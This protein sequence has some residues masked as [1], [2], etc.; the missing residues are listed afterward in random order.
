MF[1]IKNKYLGQIQI[2]FK[3]TEKETRFILNKKEEKSQG[4]LQAVSDHDIHID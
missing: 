3:F 4:H 2:R 1:F